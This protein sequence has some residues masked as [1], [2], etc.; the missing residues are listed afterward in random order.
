MKMLRLKKA[1]YYSSFIFFTGM[2]TSCKMQQKIAHAVP[3]APVI[4]K[5]PAWAAA[6]QQQAGEYKALC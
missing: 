3:D 4:L 5:G 6:W 2:A 1:F